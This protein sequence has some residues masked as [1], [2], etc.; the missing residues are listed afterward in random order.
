MSLH[1]TC[2]IFTRRLHST[3]LKWTAWLSVTLFAFLVPFAVQAQQPVR[4]GV[5]AS[6]TG[7]I[8]FVGLSHKNSMDLLPTAV[9][10]TP[11]EYIFYDDGSDPSNTVRM[12]D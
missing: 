3:I 11:I 4:I 6:V 8:A 1:T 12:V 5:V 10:G 9:E 2:P 7:P